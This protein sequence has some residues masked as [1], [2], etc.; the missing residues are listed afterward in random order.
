MKD[1]DVARRWYVGVSN[2][3]FTPIGA[4]ALALCS[5]DSDATIEGWHG[6]EPASEKLLPATDRN[7]QS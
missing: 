2:D 4:K 1:G 6:A 3:S 5:T 7:S